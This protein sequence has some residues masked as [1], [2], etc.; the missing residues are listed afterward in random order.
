MGVVG[1]VLYTCDISSVPLKP[2]RSLGKTVMGCVLGLARSGEAQCLP[3]GDVRF[4]CG[5]VS[6]E[7]LA[8]V[9]GSPW[10]I[11]SGYE[12]DGY[13]CATD[14]RN[15]RSVQLFSTSSFLSRPDPLFSDCAGPMTARFQPHGLS[16]D[17]GR[18][19]VSSER[20]WAE[21]H[22]DDALFL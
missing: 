21:R 18:K 4:V 19:A 15:H 6:P 3:D 11:V 8:V 10:V 2:T 16:C 12:V 20:L 5:P 1:S 9:P 17:R 7:D 14:S 22:S 13:L